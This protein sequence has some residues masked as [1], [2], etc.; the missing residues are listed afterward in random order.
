MDP[1]GSLIL[2]TNHQG[3]DGCFLAEHSVLIDHF[4]DEL[5]I[6]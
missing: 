4:A 5:T 3:I 6:R 1:F 2:Q